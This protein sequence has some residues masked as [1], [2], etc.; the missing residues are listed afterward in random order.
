MGNVVVLAPF[1]FLLV[2]QYQKLKVGSVLLIGLVIGIILELLQV[3]FK[4]GILDIDD[5]ILNSLGVVIGYLLFVFLKNV[6]KKTF[7]KE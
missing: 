1:G 5:I 6:F 2:I 3:I 7:K 4:S